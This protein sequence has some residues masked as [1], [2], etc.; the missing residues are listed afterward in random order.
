MIGMLAPAII[1]LNPTYPD[2]ISIN[3][4]TPSE[5]KAYDIG[6]IANNVPNAVPTPFQPSNLKN[7]G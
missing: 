6:K 4:Q 3:N 7:I 1:E 2:N 5:I